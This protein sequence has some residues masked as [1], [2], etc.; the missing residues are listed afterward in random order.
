ML[1]VHTDL[2]T[3]K[4]MFKKLY[5]VLLVGAAMACHASQSK[6]I[7][8]PGSNDLQPDTRQEIACKEVAELI[9]KYN[10]KKVDL[11]DS[12]SVVIYNRYIKKIDE[13]HTYL[14]ASDIQ[15][16]EKYKTVLDDDVQSGNLNDAFYIFNVFQK[17]YLDRIRF[18]LAHI[19]DNFDYNK[20]EDFVYDRE[21][22]PWMASQ[23]EMDENW[24]KRVKYDLLNLKVANPDMAKNKDIL[25][26]RYQDLLSQS[27]KLSNQE[28]F[29]TFMDAFTEAIDPHT[30]YFNP[31][32]AAQFNMEMSRSLEG[33]GATLSTQNE[34]VTIKSIVPGGPA[35]KSK[36]LGAD[37]RIVAV[38]QGTDGEF[39]NIVGWR[40][41]NAIALIRGKKGTVVRLQVLPGGAAAGAKPKIVEMVRERIVIKDELAKKEIR[42]YNNNGKIEKIGIINIPAFYVDNALPPSDPNFHSTTHD[43]RLILDSLK[44]EKVDGIVLDLREDGGGA[45]PEA[46]SLTGLFIKNGPVV[47]V[48]ETDGKVEVESDR[49]PSIAYSGPLAVLTDRFSASAS[50]IFAGA[51]QDYGRAVIIGSQTYGKGS[52]Q[53]EIMLDQYI[54][55]SLAEMVS[56]VAGKDSSKNASSTESKFGQLNLTIAKF[57]RITGNSTQRHGVTPDI[58]FPSL[59]PTDKYGEDTE[60]SAMPFDQIAKSDYSKYGDLNLVIPQLRKLHET[61]MSS[62]KNYQYIL[63]DIADFKKHD[64]ERSITL[65]ETQLKKLRDDEEAKTFARDNERRVALGLKPL[66]KGQ[67]KPKNE[68]LD[69][70]KIEAGQIMVDYIN[71]DPKITQV[72]SP[73]MQ[74]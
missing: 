2:K 39:Q 66:T 4:D 46:I 29:Q 38:A 41:D 72:E 58:T 54:N 27:N 19:D 34:Y 53:T 28:V 62:S 17:R 57:Y 50:E 32:N 70:L 14:L 59:I 16:F 26:K 40:I 11:N 6:P 24:V 21:D 60:P 47:Q 68:D 69:F 12:L 49:D 15:D 64:A 42:T 73:A 5:F 55:P 37:D 71:I 7:K 1:T 3:V 74:K 52:V 63:Q 20:N 56:K 67:S 45:L 22:L 25:R 33:I 43:V 9:T 8:V 65:N 36:Q 18:S 13:S 51:L 10:Y 44:A 48:K 61:R 30:S 23:A 35:D 31:F